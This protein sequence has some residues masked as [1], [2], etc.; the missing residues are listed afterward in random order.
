MEEFYITFGQSHI[1]QV[2]NTIF[3]KD[4]VAVIF[5]EDEMKAR[6]IAFEYFGPK[7]CTSYTKKTWNDNNNHYFPRGFINLN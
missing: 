1:H 7:F 5:A 4:C 6:D 2:D 3:N